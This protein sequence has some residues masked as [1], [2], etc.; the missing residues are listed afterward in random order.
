MNEQAFEH[1]WVKAM[2]Q[3]EER[4]GQPMD[5]QSALY[6]IGVNE[7]GQGPR[8]FNKDQKLDVMHVAVCAL[9][10]PYGY[11]QFDGKDK[12]GWPH[13]SRTE[14]LPKLGPKE[15]EQMMREAVLS[16]IQEW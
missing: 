16:Y 7:L 15:Q 12:D 5:L 11:Y 14:R 8:R 1:E 13:F 2:A 6:I 4:F 3:L 10:E 9:L